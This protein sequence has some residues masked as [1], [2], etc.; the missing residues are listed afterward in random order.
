[1]PGSNPKFDRYP[2][3]FV[4]LEALGCGVP[5]V[6]CRLEDESEC[7]D[8]LAQ[9]LII[10]VDSNDKSNIISGILQALEI[11]K[12]FRLGIE[13]FYYCAFEKTLRGIVDEILTQ[14]AK[15]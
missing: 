13:N 7:N 11:S 9:Q 3:R 2:F 6:G 12:G 8:S 14:S 15:T 4:F 10:Q 1:M 5:V